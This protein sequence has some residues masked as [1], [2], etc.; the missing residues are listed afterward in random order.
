LV[1]QLRV[2]MNVFD[3]KGAALINKTL[4]QLPQ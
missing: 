2:H 3:G 1:Q 4:L